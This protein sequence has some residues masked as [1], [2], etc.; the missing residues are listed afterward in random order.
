MMAKTPLRGFRTGD[1]GV[2]AQVRHRIGFKRKLPRKTGTGRSRLRPIRAPRAAS[3]ISM[4]PSGSIGWPP[5][6]M[7][8]RTRLHDPRRLPAK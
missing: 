7:V 5:Q 3:G 4:V 2:N 1:Q 8:V 6:P